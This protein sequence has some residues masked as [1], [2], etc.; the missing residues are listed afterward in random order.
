MN[1]SRFSDAQKLLMFDDLLEQVE[2]MR[3]DYDQACEDAFKLAQTLR[4]AIDAIESA[5]K[6]LIPHASV[7]IVE[8]VGPSKAQSAR[9]N[10]R[11]AA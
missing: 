2:R 3:A 1:A 4:Q 7:Q 8:D 9:K 10:T 5:V 6:L 11:S